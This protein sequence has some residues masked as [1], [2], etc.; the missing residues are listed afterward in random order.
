MSEKTIKIAVV[1]DD[2]ESIS[3]HFGKAKYYM[4]FTLD[5]ERI[6][7]AERV[8]KPVH[9][10]GHHDHDHHAH[11]HNVQFVDPAAQ[12]QVAQDEAV[13]HESMFASL[14]GCAVVLSRGMGQGAH[15]GLR[16]IGVQPIITDIHKIDEGVAAYLNGTIVDHPERLH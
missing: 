9:H 12:Q 7:T 3:A 16:A 11:E 2:G 14:H 13:R 6:V 10:H 8:E 5:G 15:M 1:T 4:I